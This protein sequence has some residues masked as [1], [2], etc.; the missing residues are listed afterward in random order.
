M[1]S[2]SQEE[3]KEETW[4]YIGLRETNTGAFRHAWQD[5]EGDEVLLPKRHVILPVGGQAVFTRV[6][7]DSYKSRGPQQPRAVRSRW[8]NDQDVARWSVKDQVAQTAK[9][10]KAIEREAAKVESLS[11]IT[12][13]IRE[14]SRTLNAP[15]RRAFAA[16]L[17]EAVYRFVDH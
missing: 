12:D 10:S 11:F 3:L 7:E 9:N 16:M 6:G 4:T 8:P 2:E 5:A 13:N 1:S 14:V 15:Q 17:L